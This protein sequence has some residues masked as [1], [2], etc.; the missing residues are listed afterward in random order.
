MQARILVADDV[1]AI[2][3]ALQMILETAGYMVTVTRDG[4][5]VIPLMQAQP[6]DLLLLDIW[7]SGFDGREICQ[8]IKQQETLHHIPLLLIS[9]HHN[10]SE[11]ATQ[12]GADG[13]ILKPFKMKTLLATVAAALQKE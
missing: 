5:Q 6:P 7:M 13:Y 8:Q 4:A 9:A 12:I 1:E 3:D 2:A 11:I 10:I